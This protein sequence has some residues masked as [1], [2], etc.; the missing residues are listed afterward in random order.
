[1]MCT[2]RELYFDWV[3]NNT[4]RWKGLQLPHFI[5][6]AVLGLFVPRRLN[7]IK[8]IRRRSLEALTSNIP[9]C[10]LLACMG[11][12]GRFIRD[13]E[14]VSKKLSYAVCMEC[15]RRPGSQG[16]YIIERY[17]EKHDLTRGDTGHAYGYARRCLGKEKWEKHNTV[18]CAYWETFCMKRVR[19]ESDWLI[20]VYKRKHLEE[21]MNTIL[22]KEEF[23]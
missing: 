12:C 4:E 7:P 22:S 19:C 17:F 18:V 23:N 20:Q 2:C 14:L 3:S 10:T 15:A 8:V 21:M 6:E 13:V 1:M 5:C 11:G 9:S 16:E